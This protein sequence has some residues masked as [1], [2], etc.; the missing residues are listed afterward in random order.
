MKIFIT[1]TTMTYL[2]GSPLYNFTLAQELA[3]Q[4]HDVSVYSAWK[5]NELRQKLEEAGVH[6]LMQV[7]TDEFDLALI[8]QPTQAHLVDAVN[9]KK[10]Y[11]IVHS[12]YDCETPI[13]NGKIDK[14]I[15]IR[16]SIQEH[17]MNEHGVDR[18]KSQVIYN[19]VDREKFSPTKRFLPPREYTKIVIPCT[20]DPLRQ[21]FLNHYI[22]KANKDYRVYIYGDHY[23]AVLEKNDYV[24]YS[25]PTFDI[26]DHIADADYVAGILLGRVNLEA[27]S[28]GIPSFIHNPKNPVE[29]EEFLLDE[30]TFDKRHNI[31]NVAKQIV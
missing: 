23:G 7:P 2:S 28:M 14:Y 24:Y 30:K 6:I 16:P 4:G 19:G 15:C 10:Y 21:E 11:N 9:S 20:L 29:C 26:Q 22:R 1:C 3:R 17:I 27:N 8:S 12:E 31:I 25:K 5:D 13:I 18:E